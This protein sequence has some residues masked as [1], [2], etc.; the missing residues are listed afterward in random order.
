MFGGFDNNAALQGVIGL[1]VGTSEKT[2]HIATIWGMFVSRNMR[3]TGLAKGLLQMA[4]TEAATTVA[5]VR[6]SVVTSNE[7]A[8]R[9]YERAGFKA[10]AVDA[11]ALCINGVFAD[12]LLMRLDFD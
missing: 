10:W 4:L 3:G 2:K 7:P 1:R 8:R 11:R 5:S 6:L 9:L 12:E